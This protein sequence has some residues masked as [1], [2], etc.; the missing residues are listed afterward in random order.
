MGSEMCIRD[1]YERGG[2]MVVQSAKEN[3]AVPGL[4]HYVARSSWGSAVQR[5]HRP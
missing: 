5:G 1:R 4:A 2:A 3:T